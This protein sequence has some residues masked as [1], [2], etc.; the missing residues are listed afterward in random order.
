MES[1]GCPGKIQVTQV[2]YDLLKDNYL[3]ED[4]GELEIKG[5]GKMHV[6]WLIGKL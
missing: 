2:V 1:H 6:Y 3:F 4:R 5:K